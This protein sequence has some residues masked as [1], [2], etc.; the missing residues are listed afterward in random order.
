MFYC[1]SVQYEAH[2]TQF[3]GNSVYKVSAEEGTKGVKRE[4]LCCFQN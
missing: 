3:M 1:M 4:V 2:L